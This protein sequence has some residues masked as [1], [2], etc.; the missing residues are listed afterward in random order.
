MFF[1]NLKK[2]IETLA[3]ILFISSFLITGSA[4]LERT[5]KEKKLGV[6][7]EDLKAIGKFKKIETVPKELFPEKLKTFVARSKKSQEEVKRIFV[8]Q[9]GLLDKY[10]HQMMKGMAYF[11]FF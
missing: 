4:G 10:P 6:F 5:E 7:K 8:D 1:K 9:K 3:L 2:I 11:E